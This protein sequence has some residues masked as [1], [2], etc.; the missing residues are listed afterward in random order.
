MSD[1]TIVPEP[2]IVLTERSD[3]DLSLTV[4]APAI[5][6]VPRLRGRFTATEQQIASKY[7]DEAVRYVP[8]VVTDDEIAEG[9]RFR[10]EWIFEP[11]PG[12]GI[13]VVETGDG[14]VWAIAPGTADEE[15]VRH[16][17]DELG[18]ARLLKRLDLDHGMV[19]WV[20][21]PTHLAN[22]A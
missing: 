16:S 8:G 9:Y 21:Q 10:D 3:G 15:E 22:A 5:Y 13:E 20:F 17:S 11:K 6:D 7:E 14:E 2:L 19:G 1:H 4:L 12:D 18:D